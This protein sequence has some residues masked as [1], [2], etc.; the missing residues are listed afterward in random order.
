MAKML[1]IVLGLVPWSYCLA[2]QGR[3][4]G[5]ERITR[6]REEG[7]AQTAT[8]APRQLMEFD[9]TTWEDEMSRLDFLDSQLRDKPEVIAY[10]VVY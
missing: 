10:I 7:V 4:D 5:S 6:L 3:S 8:D 9:I 2:L 1:L